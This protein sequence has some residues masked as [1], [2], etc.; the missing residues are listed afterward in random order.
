MLILNTLRDLQPLRLLSKPVGAGQ[1]F[2]DIFLMHLKSTGQYQKNIA[3][4]GGHGLAWVMAGGF[5]F[6]VSGL[7]FLL[8]Q[9]KV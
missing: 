4:P 7:K 2:C 1:G 9:D 6:A 3:K 5:I 8:F